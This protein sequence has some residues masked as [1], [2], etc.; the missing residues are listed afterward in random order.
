MNNLKFPG[1]WSHLHT[2]M[3]HHKQWACSK[4][5]VIS[6]ALTQGRQDALF[7]GQG[8]RLVGAR[9]VL[10]V[11]EHDNGPRT[12]LADFF[13]GPFRWRKIDWSRGLLVVNM[14]NA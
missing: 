3:N 12:P 9:S 14:A 7:H 11:R 2:F 4:R 6:P 13:T 10:G 1:A 8:R 5:P